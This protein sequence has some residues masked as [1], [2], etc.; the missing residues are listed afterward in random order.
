[1]KLLKEMQEKKNFSATEQVIVQYILANPKE[2]VD[3]AIREL[4]DKTYTSPAAVFRLCQKL[5]MK[6]YT[7]FKIKFI[8]EV[9]RIDAFDRAIGEKPIRA[10]DNV[11]SIINKVAGLEIE[12]IEETRNE[13][14]IET[15]MRIA[16]RIHAAGQVDFYAFDNNVRLA[17]LACC[18]F[19]QI[20]KMALID[21]STNFQYAQALS[22]DKTHVAIILS[23]TGE[24]KKLVRIAETLKARQAYSIVFTSSS[25][26]TLASLCD[27]FI[28]VANTKQY[29]DL[30]YFIY[31][32]GVKYLMDTLFS[33]LMAQNYDKAIG[34]DES[35]NLLMG[36]DWQAK[37]D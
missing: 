23:R 17:Q 37:R 34:L 13:L 25:K 20:G 28:Y 15:M 16:A 6:G 24:N 12:A 32:S 36:N 3:L 1:M 9:S 18:H 35:F 19:M 22:S 27:E 14:S 33:I 7:E 31:S 2:L 5:G 26:S 11:L 29:L 8:S 30:G 21:S 10:E 4:A